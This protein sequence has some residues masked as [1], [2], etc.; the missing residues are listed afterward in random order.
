[1]EPVEL[2]SPA[3]AQE[4]YNLTGSLL[5]RYALV[6]EGLGGDIPR[7]K[8]GGRLYTRELLEHFQ[9]AAER[10]ASGATVEDA[11][12]TLNVSEKLSAQAEMLSGTASGGEALEVLRQVL[13]AQETLVSEVQGLREELRRAA[14]LRAELDELR[15]EVADLKASRVGLLGMLEQVRN[16]V[17][18]RVKGR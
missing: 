9:E 14:A 8:R 6:Y 18:E 10:V 7:D 5:R 4:Q 13:S 15:R 1:M 3:D 12:K 17:V 11:L 2:L 16:Y